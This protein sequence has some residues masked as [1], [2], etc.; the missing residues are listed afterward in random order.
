M[1]EYTST[2]RL[3]ESSISRRILGAALL[4]I[5][6]AGAAS[7]QSDAAGVTPS[8]LAPGAPAGSYALSG[9]ENVNLFNGNLNF[10]LPLARVSGRGAARH[11][12]MLKIDQTWTVVTN[13]NDQ[14]GAYTYIPEPNWWEG[15]RPGYGPGVLQARH[16]GDGALRCGSSFT[17]FFN[18]VTKTLTRLTFTAS[19]GT[20]YELRDQQTGGQPQP[21][22][23]TNYNTQYNR[24]RVFVTADGTSATFISD[25][26]ITDRARFAGEEGLVTRHSGFLLLRDG[27]RYRID[28]G[29]VTWIRDRNG[30]LISF[31]YDANKRV[32]SITDSLARQATVAYDQAEGGQY[33]T[34]DRISFV[35][36]GG[37]ARVLRICKTNLGSAL[38]ATQ[39]S[40]V[41]T[42]QTYRAL[43]PELDGS[44]ST[45]YDPTV[46]GSVWLPD[47][48]RRYQL[49]YNQYGELARVVL[50]T[51]GAIEY[52]HTGGFVGGSASGAFGPARNKH[53]H[54]RVVERRVYADG[55][56]L[57]GRTTYSRPESMSG[58]TYLGSV[59]YVTAEQFDPAGVRQTFEQH[60]F[61][62]AAHSSFS[63]SAVQYASWLD[64]REYK[65]EAFDSA[66]SAVLRRVENTW[67]Q[68]A[69][70]PWWGSTQGPEPP[71][72][73]RMVTTVT[74]L[75][76][77]GANLVSKIT[78]VD[79][80]DSTGQTVGFDQYNNQTDSWLY[81]YGAGAPG[82]LLGRTHTDYLNTYASPAPTFS[83]PHMRDLMW[84]QYVYDAA[85]VARAQTAY[86]YDNYTA[87]A[88]H[89][90]PLDRPNITGLCSTYSAAGVC[91]NP[92]PSGYTTRGNVT[93]TTQYLLANDGTV[94]GALNAYVQYDV[95]GNGI[96]RIDPRGKV[97]E[98]FYG[99]SFCNGTACGGTYTANTY[100]FTTGTSSPVPD[101]TGQYGSA[102]P[103]TTSA[104]YDYYTGL[105]YSSTDANAKTT[106]YEYVDLLDRLTKV[107]RPDG[108]RTTYT[109]VDAHQCG[110]YVETRTLLDT[111]GRETDS[112]QFF[113][114][115]GRPYLSETN[116]NQDPNN[117]WLRVDTGYDAL[118]RAW[119]VSNPYRSS[120]CAAAANPS[121]RWTQTTFD[122][123]GRATQ[124]KTTADN[125]VVTTSYSGNSV[126][127][128]D[129]AGKSRRSIRDA[130]GR[131]TAVYEDP[132]GL[133]YLTSYTYDS[134]GNLRT[135][136]QG[137][138]TRTFTYDSLSRLTSATNPE[139]GTVTYG[140]DENGNLTTRADARGVNTTYAYDALNRNTLVSYSDGT[141]GV[142]RIY[143]TAENGLGRYRADWTWDGSATYYTHRAVDHYDAAGRPLDQRQ[144]VYTNNAA[145]S[146]F[147]TS[148]TYDLAGDL[149]TQTYPSGHTVS[150]NYDV[151]GRL[152]DK[153]TQPAFSGNLGDGVPR[154]YAS[155]VRYRD[156][157]DVEQERYGT[158]TP[159]YGSGGSASCHSSGR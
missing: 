143:D 120:G 127:V 49:F 18:V 50:P 119:Q 8:G 104:V 40:D 2:R 19:D 61:N 155:E 32:I 33:G 96:K 103:L 149:L 60:Y 59:G 67:R 43:F 123:L 159:V 139:S 88:S 23:C 48:Q 39:P 141:P 115:L 93:A 145:G 97:S 22:N 66:G 11:M 111:S 52:D 71:N 151:T 146:A 99:D 14:T 12:S 68:R 85:G 74:T 73:P 136:G 42:P 100:A 157:G 9:F 140:Y 65:T 5:M 31:I 152:A 10:H 37:A 58:T 56:N 122:A 80:A 15:I 142:K 83:S 113:D 41:T 147:T 150:Y 91:S 16:G 112:Y 117:L 76:P 138:Q 1:S 84:K 82:A 28:D 78:S 27:T 102:S 156:A 86:E 21:K 118:G 25:A 121:G 133:N 95:A 90:A 130:V 26:D 4:L 132:A 46:V 17:G 87:D 45:N 75:E 35:G 3:P 47:G 53:I 144:Y 69:P 34:C 63:I 153:G 129:Q 116:D 125:A 55:S 29:T 109:Y 81:D 101:P 44:N 64:G 30:N 70:V 94:T 137:G 124:V 20:E 6:S 51:G 62:G 38:R 126:T 148:R 135:V 131:L 7:A 114:G 89:A 128:T 54:R 57:E 79:P 105:A 98:V 36:F 134:L 77:G 92:S 110:P 106:A 107:T 13:F 72:D 158:D 154:T 24:G 108:G